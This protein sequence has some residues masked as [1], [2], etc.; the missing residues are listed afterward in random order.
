MTLRRAGLV[1]ALVGAVACSN[2]SFRVDHRLHWTGPHERKLTQLPVTVSWTFSGPPPATFA[3]FVDREPIKPGQTLKAVAGGDKSCKAD[4]KCPTAD[5]L[6]ARQVYT[7]T[8]TSV[9][10]DQIPALTSTRDAVQLHSA[11][12]VM[13]DA[14]GH[15]VGETAWT[16]EF[17]L[18]R[19]S[20]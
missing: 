17:K 14:T 6:A 7:T 15:R 5:Y 11:T 19:V 13:L 3:V 1:L 20:F 18:R 2:L 4:P 12:V 9:T 10:L 16:R 8:G